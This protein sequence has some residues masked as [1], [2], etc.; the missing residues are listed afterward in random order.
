M[1]KID[2]KMVC[3]NWKILD[4]VNFS[5]NHLFRICSHECISPRDGIDVVYIKEGFLKGEFDEVQVVYN[6]FKNAAT[7]ILETEQ[8]LPIK[9]LE[10]V[11]G[12][13]K[14]KPDYIYDPE[15]EQMILELVPKIL[16][17]SFY[18]FSGFRRTI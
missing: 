13:K 8:F 6:K 11:A 9:K 17:T 14:V 7:Q 4:S 2:L 10:P 15:K 12:A 1:D 16:N 18:R 5:V 3:D